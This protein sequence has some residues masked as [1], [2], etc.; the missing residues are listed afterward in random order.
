M[1]SAGLAVD[2]QVASMV[3]D[4][5]VAGSLI[6]LTIWPWIGN[7][8]VRLRRGTVTLHG[9][10]GP[11]LPVNSNL[12]ITVSGG[13]LAQLA[14]ALARQ[15]RGHWFESSIA[16]HGRFGGTPC[17]GSAIWHAQMPETPEPKD[18]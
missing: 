7:I 16:H 10:K 2:N 1:R 12:E 11:A 17:T 14:R 13:R 15:A 18:G 8:T 9:R 4:G 6:V 5:S 3:G